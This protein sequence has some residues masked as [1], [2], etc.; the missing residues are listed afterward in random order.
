MPRQADLLVDGLDRDEADVAL[1]GRSGN[2]LGVVAV[3]LGGAT[4]AERGDELGRHQTRLQAVLLAA[5]RPVMGTT[6]RFHGDRGPGR[7][8][9]QP[10]EEAVA[11][12][13]LPRLAASRP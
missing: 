1:T 2:R 11:G 12:E 6:A 3:V 5:A 8:A 9:R 4:L 10:P 7:N 13:G